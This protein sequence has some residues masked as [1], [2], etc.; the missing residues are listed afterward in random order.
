MNR[1]RLYRLPEI[2]PDTDEHFPDPAGSFPFEQQ[3]TFSIPQRQ[4]AK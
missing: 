3:M 4:S 2:S 1:P